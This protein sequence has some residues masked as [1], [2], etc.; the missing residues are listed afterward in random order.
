MQKSKL[1]NYLITF[2]DDE[3]KQFP[4]FAQSNFLVKRKGI[5]ELFNI[6]RTNINKLDSPDINKAYIYAKLYPDV[7]YDDKKIRYL[8]NHLTQSIEYFLVL[9]ELN[10]NKDMQDILLLKQC[11][12]RYPIK[13]AYDYTLNKLKDKL[14]TNQSKNVAYFDISRQMYDIGDRNFF[15]SR[16]RM[17]DENLQLAADHLDAGYVL[18]KLKY[19]CSMISRKRILS[20]EYE[21]HFL[22]DIIR[23]V[24]QPRFQ[25][26][27]LIQIYWHILQMIKD[28]GEE[29]HFELLKEAIN[30]HEDQIDFD[31]KQLIYHTAINYCLGKLRSGDEK[32][33]QEALDL[34]LAGIDKNILLQRG[35]LS[36]WTYTNIVKLALRLKKFDWIESF[37]H[38]Y[39]DKLS[40][41]FQENVVQYNLAEMYY[42][43][44]DYQ[45]AMEILQVVK[46][47]DLN[48]HLGSRIILAKC[49]YEL[50][51][52]EVLV[53]LLA[54]FNIFIKR[55]KKIS[56]ELKKTYSNFCRLL[57][58]MLKK[59]YARMPKILEEL[60]NTPLLTD[61]VWLQKVWEKENQKAKRFR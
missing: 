36:P 14:A 24:N 59:K 8:M 15:L 42:Y 21:L 10:K 6:L 61:R 18:S 23:W 38:Q 32:Y 54:S 60:N 26:V 1:I 9:E 46:F 16:S 44:N 17:N 56:S 2:S 30:K 39:R 57:N 43:K 35:F 12:N 47:S 19:F 55:N 51:E 20:G 48:F 49:Y 22:D 45:K 52:E 41:Q 33:I 7:P 25:A 13:K 37:I 40:E 34:Y 28:N 27:P 29:H 4:L 50:E 53:S 58:L 31:E 3:W 11:I 5:I